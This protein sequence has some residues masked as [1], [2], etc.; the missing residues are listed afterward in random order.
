[1]DINQVKE[2]WNKVKQ[3]LTQTLP[4]HVFNTWIVPLEAVD[5]ENNTLVLLSPQQ[6]S[7][8]IFRQERNKNQS[9][10]TGRLMKK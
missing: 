10:L 3:E 5:Y 8:N 7:V 9:F 1:M 2:V 6:M 4:E